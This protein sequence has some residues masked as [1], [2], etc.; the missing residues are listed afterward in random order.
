M[1]ST[2][3]N[4]PQRILDQGS[5][6]GPGTATHS[7]TLYKHASGALVF[8][9]GTVQWM[10]GLDSNHDRGSDAPD[11]RMQQATVNLFA[12]MGVQPDSLQ[13]GLVTA[14]ASTDAT[15]AVIAGHRAHGR[16]HPPERL[17]LPRHRHRHRTPAAWWAVWRFRRTA[18]RRGTARP[19]APAGAMRGRRARPETP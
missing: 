12:D 18:A 4:V 16:R 5:N 13:G 6:Y 9:A 2:T 8:G 19:G 11:V 17:A 10:W 14:A 15:P 1:S 3:V 7:L